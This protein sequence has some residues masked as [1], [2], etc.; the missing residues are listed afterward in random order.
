M[1]DLLRMGCSSSN[2][3]VRFEGRRSKGTKNALLVRYM[4]YVMTRGR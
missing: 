4:E 1:K 2:A 3:P